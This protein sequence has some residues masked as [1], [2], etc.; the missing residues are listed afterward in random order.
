MFS[1]SFF[2][3]CLFFFF[4]LLFFKEKS[5]FQVNLSARLV[6]LSPQNHSNDYEDDK[7]GRDP[8]RV[9]HRAT[10]AYEWLPKPH[11]VGAVPLF[12]CR[13]LCGCVYISISAAGHHFTDLLLS[14]VSNVGCYTYAQSPF[15]HIFQTVISSTHIMYSQCTVDCRSTYSF[16]TFS[17]T[18]PVRTVRE[19]KHEGRCL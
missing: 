16:R 15:V 5:F 2:F 6:S 9:T 7:R 18:R 10:A 14:L 8:P 11:N 17:A 4:L 13:T 1:P 12:L 19:C 3:F